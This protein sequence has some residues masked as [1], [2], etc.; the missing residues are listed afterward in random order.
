MNAVGSRV[1]ERRRQLGLEQDELCARVADATGGSWNPAWQDVSRIE[2][3]ASTVTDLEVIALAAAL[4]CTA[5]SLLDD[6]HLQRER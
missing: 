4:D 5:L 1:R 3:G 6:G 2:N